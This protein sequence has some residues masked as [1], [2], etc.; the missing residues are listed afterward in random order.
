MYMYLFY[1]KLNNNECTKYLDMFKQRE[2]DNKHRKQCIT[3]NNSS[4]I[5]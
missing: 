5:V 3:V 1:V 2:G 4:N